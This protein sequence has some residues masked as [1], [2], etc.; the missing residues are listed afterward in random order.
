MS[1]KISTDILKHLL[2]YDRKMLSSYRKPQT[3]GDNKEKLMGVHIF[4]KN[5]R[6]DRKASISCI[7]IYLLCKIVLEGEVNLSDRWE[8]NEEKQL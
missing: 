2:K 1:F 7:F 5:H 3:F 6:T 8:N 4:I